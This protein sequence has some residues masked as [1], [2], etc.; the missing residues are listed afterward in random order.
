MRYSAIAL[1]FVLVGCS[2]GTTSLPTITPTTT[3]SSTSPM[4]ELQPRL[5]TIGILLTACIPRLRGEPVDGMDNC[6]HLMPDVTGVVDE[7]EKQS[8][9][10]PPTGRSAIEQVRRSLTGIAPCEP[11]FAAGG[12]SA[13]GQLNARCAEAWDGLFKSYTALRNSV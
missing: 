3:S 2:T 4:P 8:D 5:D 10:L 13:D 7:A 12:A 11:W 1:A 9:K 6:A